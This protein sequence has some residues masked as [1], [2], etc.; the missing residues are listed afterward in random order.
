MSL[1]CSFLTIK[2]GSIFGNVSRMKWASPFHAKLILRLGVS[3]CVEIDP[4]FVRQLTIIAKAKF[5]VLICTQVLHLNPREQSACF[6]AQSDIDPSPSIRAAN[7][8]YNS[9][10]VNIT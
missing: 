7:Q 6:V 8:M 1:A 3:L 4:D 9:F 2:K 10:F 5:V